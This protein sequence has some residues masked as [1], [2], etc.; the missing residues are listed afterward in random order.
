MTAC[1]SFKLHRRAHTPSFPLGHSQDLRETLYRR[2]VRWR[3]PG[4]GPNISLLQVGFATLP[5][6]DRGRTNP[7]IDF[8][9]RIGG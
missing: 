8:D 2:F 9:C 6:S 7:T 1:A 5:L 3:W 4:G